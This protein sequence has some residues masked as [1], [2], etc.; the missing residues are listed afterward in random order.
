[1]IYIPLCIYFNINI[2]PAI[3]DKTTFTFHYVSIS[4]STVWFPASQNT[5]LHSTMY[6]FQRAG[7]Y[8]YVDDIVIYIPLCIYFNIPLSAKKSTMFSH[9]HSTMYLFQRWYERWRISNYKYLHSTMYLF[10]HQCLRFSVH[11]ILI[12]IPLCIYFNNDTNL[13][14]V[15]SFLIY[16]PLCIYFNERYTF[17][18]AGISKFT[19][20]YVSISTFT[21][22]DRIRIESIYIPLCI[23]FNWNFTTNFIRL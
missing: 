17:Q 12:Y 11:I 2:T 8:Y 3:Y 16:I 20:H 1:M 7:R 23:Y 14:S 4:T 5:D 9:L 6:L 15:P 21:K 22:Y 19:F 13:Y 10:Q 18:C